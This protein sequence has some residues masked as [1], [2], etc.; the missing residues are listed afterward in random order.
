MEIG[1]NMMVTVTY[2]LMVDDH[3]GEMIEQA[4]SERPLQFLLGTGMMLPKFEE[5]LTGLKQSDTF[6]IK[7]NHRDAYGEVNEEAVVDLPKHI[8]MVDGK[9]DPDSIK[10]GNT[11]PMMSGEGQRLNG[12]VLEVAEESVTMDF[13]HPLAGEDLFFSGQVVEVRQATEEEIVRT[14]SES[15]GCG[16]C[17]SGGCGDGCCSDDGGDGCGSGC[18]C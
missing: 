18:G 3:D 16:G 15:E 17:G 9:F 7:L 11:I 2:D 5:G 13:N 12:L 4:T 1:K 10:A 6:E 8:F 14:L